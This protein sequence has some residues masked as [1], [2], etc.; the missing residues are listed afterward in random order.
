MLRFLEAINPRNSCFTV[1]DFEDAL[2]DI[3]SILKKIDPLVKNEIIDPQS[4]QDTKKGLETAFL[5]TLKCL[6]A[7]RQQNS[8]TSSV[9]KSTAI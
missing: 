9:A 2:I 1:T 7:T 5:L 8:N 4:S 6:N 3:H